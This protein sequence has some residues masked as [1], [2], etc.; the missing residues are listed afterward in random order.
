[1][2]DTGALSG[3]AYDKNNIFAK[4]I[5]GE[6]PCVKVHETDDILSFMDLFPQSRG[7][8]LVIPKKAEARN[9]LDMPADALGPVFTEAQKIAKAMEKALDA[10]GIVM[11]Q[12]SGREAGQT[13]FHFHV[14]LIP[15]YAG[16]S[17]KGHAHGQKADTEE[18]KA[19]AAAINKEIA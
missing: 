5:R 12:F 13:V 19:L 1:M 7:H 10:E 2:G 4:I 15:R 8:L 16:E 17:M 6:I 3:I 11:T 9:L 14:H 18:L